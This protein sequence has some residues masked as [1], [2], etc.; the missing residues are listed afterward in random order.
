MVL[1]PITDD[2]S[3]SY[4]NTTDTSIIN[5]AVANAI[6][7]EIPAKILA[8]SG[9]SFALLAAIAAITPM[10]NNTVI[11]M[12]S[13]NTTPIFKG[14]QKFS[15]IYVLGVI[16]NCSVL[17]GKDLDLLPD[18]FVGPGRFHIIRA[19]VSEIRPVLFVGLLRVRP[20]AI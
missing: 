1:N 14:I 13:D 8:C 20:A 18:I 12:I 10:P 15:S 19:L 11:A 3:E 5:N 17:R 7:A 16:P 4:N 2:G 9:S 6:A